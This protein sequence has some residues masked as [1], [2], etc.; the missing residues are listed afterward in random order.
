M[1]KVYKTLFGKRFPDVCSARSN[2]GRPGSKD[3]KIKKPVS[4][5]MEGSDL[6]RAPESCSLS[7]SILTFER[8]E[9][10]PYEVA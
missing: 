6:W 8:C 2:V 3:L 7:E 1:H 4:A 9:I 5:D 10:G